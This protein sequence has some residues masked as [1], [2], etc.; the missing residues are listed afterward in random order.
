MSPIFSGLYTVNLHVAHSKLFGNSLQPVF[1]IPDEKWME[2]PMAAV[3]LKEGKSATKEELNSFI[4]SQFT[5]FWL[6]DAYDFVKEIPKT[7]VGK[8]KKSVLRERYSKN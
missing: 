4:E 6:P 2:R 7:S 5:K 1:A 8:F 3:V